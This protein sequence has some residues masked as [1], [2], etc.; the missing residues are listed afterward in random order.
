MTISELRE[1]LQ[2]DLLAFTNKWDLSDEQRDDLWLVCQIIIDR[3]NEFAAG[4]K[5]IQYED[6]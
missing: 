5:S 2:E 4:V 1:Q 6:R 3:V